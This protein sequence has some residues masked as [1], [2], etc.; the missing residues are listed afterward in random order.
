VQS[1]AE[2]IE[3]GL[4]LGTHEIGELVEA[5]QHLEVTLP[6]LAARNRDDESLERLRGIADEMKAAGHDY[7][8]YIDADVEFHLEIARASR[9]GALGGVLVNIRSLLLVW[10]TRVVTAAQETESSLAMH[11]PVLEAIERGDVEGARSTME[12]LME[13]ASRRLHATAGSDT[14]KSL[15]PEH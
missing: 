1:V 8:R 13:R 14:T 2:V 12:A 4:L 11:L 5:R 3:W 7:Q 9:N 15:T 6:G 10:T